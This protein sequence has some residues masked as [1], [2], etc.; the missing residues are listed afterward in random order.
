MVFQA[1]PAC[2]NK[3]RLSQAV[4]KNPDG[5][6]LREDE[7]CAGVFCVCVFLFFPVIA[8]EHMWE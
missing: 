6:K 8:A 3:L 2:S 7:L 5:V 1:G 4:G